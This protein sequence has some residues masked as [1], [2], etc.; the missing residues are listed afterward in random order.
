M[1]GTIEI[2]GQEQYNIIDKGTPDALIKIVGLIDQINSKSLSLKGLSE[3]VDA[4]KRLQGELAGMYAT[5]T[6]EQQG[7]ALAIQRLAKANKDNADAA[8]KNAKAQEVQNKT[9][10]AN[11]KATNDNAAALKARNAELA[12]RNIKDIPLTITNETRAVEGN[13]NAVVKNT[14]INA[15]NAAEHREANEATARQTQSIVANTSATA[16]NTTQKE[17]AI[18]AAAQDAAVTRA[19]TLAHNENNASIGASTPTVAQSTKGLRSLWSGLRNIAYILPGIGIAGIFNL[20]FIAI[21][22]V[23][24]AIFE[25]KKNVDLLADAEKRAARDREYDLKN[26]TKFQKEYSEAIIKSVDSNVGAYAK[27]G[28]ELKVL[29]G[30]ATNLNLS[31]SDRL[32]ATKELQE[33]YPGYFGNLTTEQI[34]T[35]N[36]TA[37]YN[38]LN[39][40]LIKRISLN[41]Y[42]EELELLVKQNLEIQKQIDK[43]NTRKNTNGQFV[44]DEKETEQSYQKTL[45]KRNGLAD[46]QNENGIKQKGILQQIFSLESDLS[47]LL[48]DKSSKTGSSGSDRVKAET[49]QVN[50]IVEAN[51]RLTDTQRDAKVEELNRIIEINKNIFND[52]KRTIQERYDAYAEMYAARN[53]VAALNLDKE[54]KDVENWLSSYQDEI[55]KAQKTEDTKRTEHQKAL[56]IDYEEHLTRKL[57]LVKKY[58]YEVTKI[59]IDAA[60]DFSEIIFKDPLDDDFAKEL[61]RKNSKLYSDL[62]KDRKKDAKELIEISREMTSIALSGL[63]AASGVSAGITQRK[64]NNLDLENEKIQQNLQDELDAI[65]LS[66]D[67]EVEKEKKIADAKGRAA[68]QEKAIADEQKKLK[69]EQ[70]KQDKAITIANIILKTALAVVTALA[71][72][73]PFTKIPRAI[74]AGAL[75]ASQLAIAIATPIPQYMHGIFGDESHPGGNMIVGDGGERELIISGNKMEWSPSTATLMTRPK[76][77]QVIPEHVLMES[78]LNGQSSL[79]GGSLSSQ[80]DNAYLSEIAKGNKRIESAIKNTPQL[81]LNIDRYGWDISQQRGNSWTHYENS[82]IHR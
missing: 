7:A 32:K 14:V 65:Q 45:E 15:A 73:D 36:A 30:S 74:A 4:A 81:K 50:E 72:G 44:L 64:L 39:G 46:L 59:S 66:G 47:K 33:M 38:E 68:A 24:E 27:E 82:R 37:A 21:V 71:E 3:S 8:L 56:L 25:T 35:G 51:K 61:R 67:S 13:S 16:A 9:T 12:K 80:K 75:G 58:E 53:E 29:Y 23:Y 18:A 34:L 2:I 69:T 42:E 41:V 43:T 10:A 1:D 55:D 77:T 60:K 19:N 79:N 54:L 31:M 48:V 28:A 20:A 57:A 22:K 63:D 62:K 52:E 76:G 6:K 70:A 17:I 49:D 26:A 78:I 11:T 5:I 40:A